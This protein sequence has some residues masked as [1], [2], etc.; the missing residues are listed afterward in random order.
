MVA[1]HANWSG[2]YSLTGKMRIINLMR[3]DNW[4]NPGFSD[5]RS[6][7]LFATQP[8]VPGQIGIQLP[9]AQFSPLVP[10]APAFLSICPGPNYDAATCPQH[11]AAAL[12]DFARTLI[13]TYLGQKMLSNTVQLQADITKRIS[14]RI[15][16]MYEDRVITDTGYFGGTVDYYEATNHIPP[17]AN[18]TYYPGGA[19]GTAANYFLA[20]RGLCAIPSGSSTLPAGCNLNADSTISYVNPAPAS[21]DRVDLPIAEHVGLAGFTLR[22]IDSLRINTDFQFGY[23]NRAYTQI[24][25]RQFQSYKIHATYKPKPWATIDGAIDVHENRQRQ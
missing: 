21:S 12:P 2:V 6:A 8:Q 19:A 24:F 3:Y 15:G 14:G 10:G 9:Q 4:R 11:T 13:S 7:T 5:L 25:P 16:Y 17:Y 18:A 22:P 1:V 23:N 20:A